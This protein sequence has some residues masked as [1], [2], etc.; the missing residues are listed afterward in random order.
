MPLGPARSQRRS[1]RN[2]STDNQFHASLIAIDLEVPVSAVDPWPLA[3]VL[4]G[5]PPVAQLAPHFDVQR[6][7]AD[8]QQLQARRW[9]DIRTIAGDG[10]GNYVTKLDW[11]TIPLRSIGGDGERGD[12]GG[13]GLQGY[14]NTPWL[15]DMPYLAEVLAAIPAP[16]GSARLMALGPG[17]SSPVHSDTKI[18]FPWGSVRLHVPIVTTPE[19]TLLIAEQRHYWAPGSLWYADFTRSHMVENT[20]HQTR[21]HLVFD[22]FV[23]SELLDLFP[24]EFQTAAVRECS[25]LLRPEVP[26]QP[27]QVDVLRCSFDLPASFRSWDEPDGAFLR[28]QEKVPACVD[29]YAS[30]LALHLDGS[31]AFRLIH[32]GSG[33]FRFA[34]WTTERTLQISPN[35]GATEVTLRTRVGDQVRTLSIQADRAN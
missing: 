35:G 20:G 28:D 16:I 34:G 6:L 25:V 21:V 23:T 15:S 3:P 27:E 11:R 10:L 19:A 5:L 7:H 18:G 33:E 2:T 29:R 9:K 26:L 12:A 31:P 22:A 14:A 32:V 13:P 4:A 1:S 24:A 17:A 8:L 30:G